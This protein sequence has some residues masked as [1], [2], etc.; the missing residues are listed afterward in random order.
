[1]DAPENEDN[2][3]LVRYWFVTRSHVVRFFLN[4]TVFLLHCPVVR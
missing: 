3:L 2:A 4:R 1:M